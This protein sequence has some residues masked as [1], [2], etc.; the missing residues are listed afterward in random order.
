MK[1]TAPKK[2][3]L[4]VL[5]ELLLR[6]NKILLSIMINN[7]GG[8]KKEKIAELKK[9]ELEIKQQLKALSMLDKK[10]KLKNSPAK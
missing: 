5:F 3:R 7:I 10:R 1:K 8:A 9:V 6:Q 2:D 4:T